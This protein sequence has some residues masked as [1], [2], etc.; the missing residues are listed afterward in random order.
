M[1][2]LLHPV[3]VTEARERHPE[4]RHPFD[5]FRVEP[6]VLA[7]RSSRGQFSRIPTRSAAR[8]GAPPIQGDLRPNR[9]TRRDPGRAGS[10]NR[11][12][13]P[14]VD[15]P[16]DSASRV[17]NP[18]SIERDRGRRR[19]RTRGGLKPMIGPTQARDAPSQAQGSVDMVA[20]CDYQVTRR[21]LWGASIA[22][23]V[24]F[25]SIGAIIGLRPGTLPVLWLSVAIAL[26][27]PFFILEVYPALDSLP[28][29]VAADASGLILVRRYMLK[30]HAERHPW[31]DIVTI[32]PSEGP[33]RRTGRYVVRYRPFVDSR[34]VDAFAIDEVE[35]ARL[36]ARVPSEVMVG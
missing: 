18:G 7:R 29:H 26:L 15:E 24:L 35:F 36:R 25:L 23:A 1:V 5:E 33:V 3:L 21:V 17:R 4:T 13:S 14:Q 16:G 28:H 10:S 19:S 8:P 2:V 27:V 34:R 12:P 30:D 20:T 9:R 11:R 31:R 22:V 6:P 32:A